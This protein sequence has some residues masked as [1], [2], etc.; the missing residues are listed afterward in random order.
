MRKI[1]LVFLLLLMIFPVAGFYFFSDSIFRWMP[2]PLLHEEPIKPAEAIVV[3][4]G[5]EGIRIEEGTRLYKKGFGK[6]LIFSGFK[7][8]SSIYSHTLMM[9]YA[10]KLGVPEESIL[11][12]PANESDEN[13]TFGEAI[14]NL[15]L[16]RKN[17]IKSFIVVTSN[18]H[19][20]R[21]WK[22]YQSLLTSDDD[23]RFTVFPVQDPNF[24]IN[25]WWKHRISKKIIFFEYVK[26]VN[27]SFGF[28]RTN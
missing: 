11:A 1:V 21:V 2:T 13:S 27:D 5:G 18:Y 16:I 15:R 24:P 9:D 19:S 4:A 17:K 6:Y 3:L 20:K 8:Y 23:I 26:M 14:S 7:V 12:A 28:N 10:E 22:I 25:S